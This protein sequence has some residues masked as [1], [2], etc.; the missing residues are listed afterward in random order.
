MG[1]FD[2]PCSCFVFSAFGA[3]VSRWSGAAASL[4]FYFASTG[5]HISISQPRRSASE[6][7][8]A[9][10]V[11]DL[12]LWPEEALSLVGAVAFGD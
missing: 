4:A 3:A 11:C 2:L 1:W 9:D 12:R 8:P 5:Q 10:G 7:N 6:T